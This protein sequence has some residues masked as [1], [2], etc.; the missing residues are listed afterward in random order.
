MD[1]L[2]RHKRTEHGEDSIPQPALTM[3][4]TTNKKT[5]SEPKP[6]KARISGKYPIAS[7]CPDDNSNEEEERENL[8]TVENTSNKLLLN[9]TSDYSQYR[10]AKAQL[11]Y[12]LRE[13]EML[14]EEYDIAQKKIKRLK[15][16]REVL[17]ESAMLHDHDE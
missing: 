5:P 16:E 17:L 9:V 14:Q 11:N 6:K 7:L 2:T 12:L 13:N 3:K 1:A 10:I 8:V 4:R 15:T